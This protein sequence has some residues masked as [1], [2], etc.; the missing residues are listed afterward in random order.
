MVDPAVN[1]HRTHDLELIRDLFHILSE[2]LCIF[3]AL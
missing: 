2:K 1:Q 3:D